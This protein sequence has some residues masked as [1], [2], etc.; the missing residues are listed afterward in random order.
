M[1]LRLTGIGTLP[2]HAAKAYG[3]RPAA[4]PI[5]PAAPVPLRPQP[6]DSFQPSR[7]VQNLV[8]GNVNQAVDFASVAPRPAASSHA[9]QMYTRAADKIEAAVAVQIGRTLDVQG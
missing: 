6:V 8:A 5:A 1:D 4:A 3:V 9:L 7:A 2:L